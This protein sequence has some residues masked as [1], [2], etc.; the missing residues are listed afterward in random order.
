MPSC[1]RLVLGLVDI[2][3]KFNKKLM[4]FNLSKV[5]RF[6]SKLFYV[7]GKEKNEAGGLSR[8]CNLIRSKLLIQFHFNFQ[9]LVVDFFQSKFWLWFA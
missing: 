7:A 9:S 2:L 1:L 4:I 3:V 5:I 6:R 8:K